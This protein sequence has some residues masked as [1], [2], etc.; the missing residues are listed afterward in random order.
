MKRSKKLERFEV[1]SNEST[2]KNS[3]KDRNKFCIKIDK[4]REGNLPGAQSISPGRAVRIR[5]SA[6]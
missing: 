5:T 4:E 3:L 1:D 6:E 2:L